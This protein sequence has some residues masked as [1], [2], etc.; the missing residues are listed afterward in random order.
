[1]TETT[2]RSRIK[3]LLPALAWL[4][5]IRRQCK[6][7]PVVKTGDVHIHGPYSM[8]PMLV[9]V[10]HEYGLLTRLPLH[11]IFKTLYKLGCELGTRGGDKERLTA[12][13]Q[14]PLHVRAGKCFAWYPPVHSTQTLIL[15]YLIVFRTYHL[16]FT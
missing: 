15:I 4:A 7:Y 3:E 2:I 10:K 12:Q 9:R 11:V 5:N 13:P 14:S 8:P 1:M 16:G 6:S